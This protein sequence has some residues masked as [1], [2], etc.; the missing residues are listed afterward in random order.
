MK[1][2]KADLALSAVYKNQYPQDKLK[3]VVFL[4]RSNVG[5]SSLLNTLVSRRSLAR[6][7]SA[8]G[9]TRL[10]NFFI[11]EAVSD[12]DQLLSCFFVDLPGYGYAK[13]SKVEREKFLTMIEDF[14]TFQ[15]DDKFCLQLVDI[16]HAPSREDVAMCDIL[17]NAGYRLKIIA[18][19]ADKVT[20]NI[21]AKNLRV[22]AQDLQVPLEDIL[23]F[24]AVT[25]EG[26]DV[27]LSFIQD[28]LQD[29]E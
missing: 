26:R 28:F 7:S 12:D 21:R 8:P 1:I 13:V 27:L 23:P 5:K 10:I 3:Q 11:L 16:R 20:K 15:K 22:I 19:K 18:T 6:I 14:L 24:S 2:K 17:H 4:G 29:A 9:K 25:K